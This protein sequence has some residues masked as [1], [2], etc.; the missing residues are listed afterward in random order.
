[1]KI[2]HSR[3]L[4]DHIFNR[5]RITGEPYKGIGIKISHSRDLGDH[6]SKRRR[7]R[8]EPYIETS[9]IGNKK[10]QV[11]NRLVITIAQK[12]KISQ[13]LFKHLLIKL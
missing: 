12:L 10:L 5:R 4:V 9:I 11:F 3:D 13:Y 6:I 7:I 1:M 8:G 2:S